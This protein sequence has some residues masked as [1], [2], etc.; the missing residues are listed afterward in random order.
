[1]HG[2]QHTIGT[3]LFPH[4]MGL[5]CSHNE[6]NFENMGYWTKES[7][8]R[9]G[10]NYAFAPTVAVSHNPQ[11]GRYYETMGQEPDFIAKYAESFVRGLQDISNSRIN[12]VLAGAKSF[13]GDGTS[14]YGCDLGNSQVLNFS[15]YFSHNAG[16]YSGSVRSN[17]GS[18]MAGYNAINWIPN[19]INSHYLMGLLREDLNFNGFTISDYNDVQ[20]HTEM[21][22]PRTFMNFTQE[23]DA[24]AAMV[25]GGVDMFMVQHKALA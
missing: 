9:V 25:N 18:V 21:L 3:V 10:F 8:K 14:L 13:I 20:A 22:L 5:S 16:G 1:V 15:N 11:W 19:S 23:E 12:G 24:Y 7:M 17:V 2:D 4:N 6:A